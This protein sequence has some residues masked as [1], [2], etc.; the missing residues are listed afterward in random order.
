MKKASAAILALLGIHQHLSAEQKQDLAGAVVVHT[1]GAAAASAARL[2]HNGYP[3]PEAYP[4]VSQYF[5]IPASELLFFASIS[6]IV[7]QA[8]YLIWKWRRDYKREQLRRSMARQA[9][10][11][12]VRAP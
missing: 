4:G 9:E 11:A 5:G 1:P 7:L 10:E 6:F 8:A 2:T 12:K 3:S